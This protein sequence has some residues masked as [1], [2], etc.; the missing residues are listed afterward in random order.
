MDIEVSHIRTSSSISTRGSRHKSIVNMRSSTSSSAILM[1][2]LSKHLRRATT[3]GTGTVKRRKCIS[4]SPYCSCI[5]Y[6]TSSSSCSSLSTSNTDTPFYGSPRPSSTPSLS[7]LQSLTLT[8]YAATQAFIDPE[9]HEMV[10]TLSELTGQIA[11]QN[12][13]QTMKNNPTGQRILQTKPIVSKDTIDILT[14]EQSHK[15]TFGHAYASFLK[16]NDFD[17]DLRAKVKY[18]EDEELKY[19]M[20][21]YRQCHDFYHV[22][23]DLP[24]TIPGE[25]ALK[26]VELFQ[27]GLPACALSAT[28]GS[29]KLEG[30]EREKWRDVY[31]PW[32]IRVGKGQTKWINVYWEEMFEWNIEELRRE[33][34]IESAPKV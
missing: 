19:V 29:W 18:I 17:P 16:E 21:R 25:L 20:M 27:T 15:S 9:K 34:N 4:Q 6:S 5:P 31:L 11:L 33:L 3:T 10:A 1:N 14:L 2:N 23:T 30:E 32:A 13:Y 24:P 22:I 12:M 28:V 26:Y 7:T 8:A